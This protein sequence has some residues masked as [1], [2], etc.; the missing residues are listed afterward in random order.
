MKQTA[1]AAAATEAD[2]AATI[3]RRA[4]HYM[5]RPMKVPPWM[6]LAL[7]RDPSPSKAEWADMVAAL[8][9]GDPAMDKC[10]AWMFEHGAREGRDLF[11][12]ALANGIDSIPDAP[13]PLRDFFNEIERV[14]DWVDWELLDEGVRFHHRI[15][16]AGPYILRDLALMGGY[17]LSGFNQALVLTGALNK[18]AGQRIAETGKWWMDCTEEN[19]LRRFGPGFRSSV[20]VRLIHA[21]VRRHLPSRPEWDVAEYGLPVNQIDMVATYLAFGPI[22]LLGVRAMG[23]PVTRR[24]SRAVMHLWKYVAW[25]MGVEEK[26]LC[27]DERQGLVRLYHTFVTQSPPD[28]T[29]RELGHALSEEPLTREIP[30]LKD[31]PKVHEWRL[32][33]QYQMHLSTTSLFLSKKQR[34]QLGLPERIYPWFPLLTAGPRFVWYSSQSIFPGSRRRLEKL[35]RFLQVNSLTEMYGIK[36]DFAR[37]AHGVKPAPGAPTAMPAAG[38]AAGAHATGAAS[39][40]GAAGAG[41]AAGGCPVAH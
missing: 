16:L 23:I 36:P 34:R 15:G 30:W 39:T 9:Q 7:G 19:G 31:F 38:S 28:W 33:L 25:L 35:G 27:D 40:G 22:M 18:G 8:M 4:L 5:N 20:E 13:A 11:Y 21:M 10:V 41:P 29:S 1:S 17:L 12:R 14:P 2:P 3:P 32:K 24:D 26:W 6:R 37:H